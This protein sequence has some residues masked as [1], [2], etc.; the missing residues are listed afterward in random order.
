M[1]ILAIS[2]MNNTFNI[3][4]MDLWNFINDEFGNIMKSW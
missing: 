4:G 1:I 2:F 3:H